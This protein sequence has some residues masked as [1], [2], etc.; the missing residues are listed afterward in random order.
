MKR[1]TSTVPTRI[2]SYRCLP[3]TDHAER[4]LVERQFKLAHEYRNKLV[5][6]ERTLRD[7][8]LDVVLA[9]PATRHAQLRVLDSQAALDDAYDDLRAAKSGGGKP[10]EEELERVAACKESLH[11]ARTELRALKQTHAEALRSG[12]ETVRAE[13][14]AAVKAARHDFSARGLRHGAYSRIEMAVQQA[15]KAVEPPTF[16]RYDGS[17]SIGTQLT[18]DGPIKGLTL[19]ELYSCQDTRVRLG[20]PGEADAHPRSEVAACASWA[21][22]FRLPRNL[23]RHAARTYFWLRLGSNPDRSP[24]FARFLITYHRP[25]PSD[26]VIKWAYVVRKR[27]GIRYEWRLQLTIE[28]ETFAMPHIPVGSG[29]AVALNVGW[30]NLFDVDGSLIG[31]RVGY[32]VD[33]NGVEREIRVPEKTWRGLDKV[34]DL[35]SIRAKE[36]DLAIDLLCGWI[37]TNDAPDWL[38]EAARNA[39]Q[40]SAQRR[41]AALIDRW[42]QPVPRDQIEIYARLQAWA[43]QD[44]HLLAWERHLTDRVIAHRRETYRVIAAEICHR[45]GTIILGEFDLTNPK[46]AQRP[47][48]EDGDPA[49]GRDQRRTARIAAPGELRDAIRKAA[50]KHGARV[51]EQ[52]DAY[53]TVTCHVCR[54]RETW[55]R[56]AE[57]THVCSS[58]NTLW[59]QDANACRNHLIAW[60]SNNPPPDGSPGPRAPRSS[61]NTSVNRGSARFTDSDQLQT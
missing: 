39:R 31:I 13:A 2:Y 4:N 28:S 9:H 36:F 17:G 48:P 42:P 45:Y 55:N 60:A 32:L 46:I 52:D 47:R 57:I 51:V 27:I 5:E 54:S 40:W 37:A 18:G 41:L 20:R 38:R 6:I 61:R 43:K 35:S 12:Y 58:C 3:P 21:E 7:R 49:E 25:L 29:G 59:D 44:R 53:I 30:R 15:A 10:S 1:K 8:M 56:R 26:A 24:I 14:R 50:H 11:S 16:E 19:D 34:R 23:R 22:A 33:E